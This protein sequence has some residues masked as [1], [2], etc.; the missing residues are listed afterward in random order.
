M[1]D[2]SDQRFGTFRGGESWPDP[3]ELGRDL[4]LGYVVLYALSG[5]DID[6]KADRT[7][8][9]QDLCKLRYDAYLFAK[10]QFL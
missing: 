6:L 10:G 2:E 1:V 4:Y 5:A 8:I 3:L 7:E 9:F